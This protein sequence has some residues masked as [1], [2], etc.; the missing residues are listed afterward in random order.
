MGHKVNLMN[1]E[2]LW[3]KGPGSV[4]HHLVNVTTVP[5]GFV[6]FILRHHRVAFK[7]VGELI[8][9]HSYYQVSVGEDIFG[10]HQSASMSR[11]EK[12]KDPIS[13]DSHRTMSWRAPPC[14]SNGQLFMG[15]L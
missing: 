4:P 10:L 12:I 15:D 11:M 8:T 3:G 9:A 5:E 13:V 6:A 2:E 7:L 14:L 1:L